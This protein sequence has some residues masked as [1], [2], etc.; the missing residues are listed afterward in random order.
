M[1]LVLA[2][3]V[4]Y[5]FLKARRERLGEAPEPAGTALG[6]SP[7]EGDAGVGDDRA[8]LADEHRV[9]VELGDLG[10]V[11]DHGADPVRQLGEGLYRSKMSRLGLT[12][13]FTESLTRPGGTR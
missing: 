3:L 1:V 7:G 9:Q 4:P 11:L 6:S 5:T 8:A 10:D 12:C 2:D 13:E